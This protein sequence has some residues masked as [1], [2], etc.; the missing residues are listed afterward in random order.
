MSK[1]SRGKHQMELGAVF[2]FYILNV[3]HINNR[4]LKTGLSYAKLKMARRVER[5]RMAEASRQSGQFCFLDGRWPMARNSPD[6]LLT[7]DGDGSWNGTE[8]PWGSAV[9]F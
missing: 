2:I 4:P 6:T 7:Q 1:S 3:P 5:L 9:R 8:W